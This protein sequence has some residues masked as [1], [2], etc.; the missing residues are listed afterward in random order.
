MPSSQGDETQAPD[1]PQL[2]ISLRADPARWLPAVLGRYQ[3]PLLRHAGAILFDAAAAQDVVQE[4]FLKLLANGRR[5]DDLPSWLHRVTHNLAVDH[6][7][8]E[9]RLKKLHV[10]ASRGPE[11]LAESADRPLHRK[12]VAQ[13]LQD[14]LRGLTANERAV[15]F[16]KIKEGRSYREISA[17]T[18]LS[19]SN[20]GYLVHQAITKLSAR[21]GPVDAR[22]GKTS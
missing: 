6:L 17:I 4:S 2:L 8:R 1:D 3:A 21:L 13:R 19:A 18:G 5:I 22:K 10:E 16:L 11:P 15:L 12:E 7:R 14:E 9:T 20:V